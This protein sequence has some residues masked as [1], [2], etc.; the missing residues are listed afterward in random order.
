MEGDKIRKELE[1]KR[2]E[3]KKLGIT[4][5]NTS[6]SISNTSLTSSARPIHAEPVVES[7]K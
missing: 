1:K 3:E 6:R 5:M 2:I 7:R 4:G